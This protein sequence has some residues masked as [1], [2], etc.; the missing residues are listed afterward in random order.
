MIVAFH[1]VGK[2]ALNADLEIAE[3]LFFMMGFTHVIH[4]GISGKLNEV[5]LLSSED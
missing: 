4:V 1:L 5:R 2:S 3:K